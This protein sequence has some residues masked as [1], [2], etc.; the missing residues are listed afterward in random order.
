M[1]K[2]S[3]NGIFWCTEKIAISHI[4]TY[5]QILDWNAIELSRHKIYCVWGGVCSKQSHRGAKIS[6]LKENYESSVFFWRAL[7]LVWEFWQLWLCLLCCVFT[8]SIIYLKVTNKSA[9]MMLLLLVLSEG[10]STIY[11]WLSQIP[12]LPQEAFSLEH[13]LSKQ[14]MTL[15]ASI[16]CQPTSVSIELRDIYVA[17][18]I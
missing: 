13:S 15:Q 1:W 8:T 9:G 14:A 4:Y 16:S 11:I 3:A 12:V 7:S 17:C 5:R 2:T 18:I 10:M 6:P